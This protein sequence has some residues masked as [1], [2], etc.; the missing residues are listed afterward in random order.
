M[1]QWGWIL[2][3]KKSDLEPTT[4]FTFV[5]MVFN[6]T[7]YTVKPTLNRVEA[8]ESQLELLS[9]ASITIQSL[10]RLL[11]I[12]ISLGDLV[13]MGRLQRRPFQF[14]IRQLRV[15]SYPKNCKKR[16]GITVKMK[17][18]VEWWKHRRNTMM[19]VSMRDRDPEIML[20]TDASRYGWGAVCINRT[21][22]QVWNNQDRSYHIN[23]LEMMAIYLAMQTFLDMLKGKHAMIMTDNVSAMCYIRKLGEAVYQTSM[24]WLIG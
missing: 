23:V 16:V 3:L 22:Q 21:T 17:E 14:A 2:N 10:Q 1:I 6:T 4:R 18:S 15:N 19:G 13:P 9:K 7:S 20:T 11:G 8:S 24:Y 12:L 5:G